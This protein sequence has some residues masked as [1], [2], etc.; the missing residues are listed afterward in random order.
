MNLLSRQLHESGPELKRTISG[1]LNQMIDTEV[2]QII[3]TKFILPFKDVSDD[4]NDLNFR[5]NLY[6]I[7]A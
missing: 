2:K 5:N 3:I 1:Q 7:S 4:E 6:Q